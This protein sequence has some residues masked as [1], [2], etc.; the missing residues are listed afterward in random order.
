MAIP[1]IETLF[2]FFPSHFNQNKKVELVAEVSIALLDRREVS[3]IF[4]EFPMDS[5]KV[6]DIKE[7]IAEGIGKAMDDVYMVRVYVGVQHSTCRS[8]AAHA[9]CCAVFR[10]MLYVCALHSM[11]HFYYSH[12]FST[13]GNW[14]GGVAY[15]YIYVLLY[16][17]VWVGFIWGDVCLV[18]KV[19]N[20]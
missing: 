13:G 10:C 17:L 20:T 14:C 8:R 6:K 1:P 4:D 19:P 3:L 5:I 7:V 11:P 18:A 16:C 15:I 9:E 12:A 2:F